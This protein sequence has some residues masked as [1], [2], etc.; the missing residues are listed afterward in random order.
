MAGVILAPMDRPLDSAVAV[1]GRGRIGERPGGRPQAVQRDVNEELGGYLA[2]SHVRAVEA[3]NLKIGSGRGW[4][5]RFSRPKLLM[6]SSARR[7]GRRDVFEP[8]SVLG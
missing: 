4:A 7:I 2:A 6:A 3:P 1:Q 5:T 8:T